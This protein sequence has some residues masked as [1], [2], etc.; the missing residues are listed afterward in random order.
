METSGIIN[1]DKELCEG[2]GRCKEICPVDAIY[3]EE[4]EAYTI[5]QDKCVMC[6]QCV[7]IGRAHV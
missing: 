3:G 7:Q 5:D 1:I 2:C 6:G 4:G